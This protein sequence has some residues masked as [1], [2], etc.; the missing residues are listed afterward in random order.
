MGWHSDDEPE[1]GTDPLIA[2]VSLGAARR[3]VLKHK[4]RRD[5]EPVELALGHG[6][7]LVMRGSTQVHWRHG[8]PKTRAAVAERL[9]LTFR[10]IVN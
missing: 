2:S 9:N 3:F 8:V 5:L 4:K 10:R 6:A 1:L 7:L